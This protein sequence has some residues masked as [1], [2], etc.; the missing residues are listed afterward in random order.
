MPSSHFECGA[1]GES[2]TCGGRW[3]AVG[4]C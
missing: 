4:L 3:E 1:L 2:A